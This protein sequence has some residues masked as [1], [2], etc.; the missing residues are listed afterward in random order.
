MTVA[1]VNIFNSN[2][3]GHFVP[4]RRPYEARFTQ[5]IKVF[6]QRVVILNSNPVDT[7][8]PLIRVY[9]QLAPEAVPNGIHPQHIMDL[10]NCFSPKG[11]QLPTSTAVVSIWNQI[12][13]G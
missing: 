12:V 11:E 2:T 13:I 7:N 8:I 3:L 4:A 6:F 5:L 1:L 9:F 10:V